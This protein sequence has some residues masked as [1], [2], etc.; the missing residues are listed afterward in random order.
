MIFLLSLLSLI[1]SSVF[2]LLSSLLLDLVLLF[3]TTGCTAYS[4]LPKKNRIM[5]LF[6]LP[7]SIIKKSTFMSIR[8]ELNEYSSV[9]TGVKPDPSLQCPVSIFPDLNYILTWSD[10]ERARCL[11]Y[12][13]PVTAL[14]FGYEY[15]AVFRSGNYSQP[16][17][18]RLFNI[19]LNG[20]A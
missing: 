11:T 1:T 4:K 20:L 15:L 17:R 10:R 18:F 12:I 7:H 6:M 13:L 3:L 8:K 9:L 16:C 19:D 2:I 5:I 14:S